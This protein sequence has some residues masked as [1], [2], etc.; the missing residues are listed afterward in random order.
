MT[1]ED[2]ISADHDPA[3]SPLNRGREGV[4]QVPFGGRFENMDHLQAE[5]AGQCL[6]LCYLR[7]DNN[8]VI[9]RVDKHGH[10]FR[11]G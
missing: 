8:R 3:C 11:S 4:I 5:R 7:F 2:V 6:C 9:V 1:Q 10:S